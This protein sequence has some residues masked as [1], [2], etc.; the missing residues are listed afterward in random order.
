MNEYQLNIQKAQQYVDQTNAGYQRATQ[1]TK[2]AQSAY[3]KAFS[4]TPDYGTLY[5]QYKDQYT[6][7]PELENM[8]NSYLLAKDNVDSVRTR[9]DKLSDSINQQFGGTSLTEAQREMFKQKQLQGLQR[10]FTQY[11]ANYNVQFRDYQKSVDRAFNQALDVTNKSYDN[12]WNI[13]KIKY[14]TWNERIK[15][16]E[17][18]SDSLSTANIQLDKANFNYNMYKREQEWLET[19]R[20]H[21]E[22]MNQI[23]REYVN[24]TYN[25]KAT[26]EASNAK[27]MKEEEDRKARQQKFAYDTKLFQS[28]KLSASEYMRRMDAGLYRS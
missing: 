10:Q 16:E 28:G 6:K 9:I 12:Y 23:N 2:S 18:W 1:E 7:D 15:T 22:R 8:K 19:L 24:A 4:S 5:D 21:E 25:I 3:E 14:D 13:V 26:A 11:N 20:K 17:K 27:R